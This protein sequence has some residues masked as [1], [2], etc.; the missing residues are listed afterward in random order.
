MQKKVTSSLLIIILFFLIFNSTYEFANSLKVTTPNNISVPNMDSNC[1]YTKNQMINYFNNQGINVVD[2]VQYSEDKKCSGKVVGSNLIPGSELTDLDK[3]FIISNISLY[4]LYFSYPIFSTISMLILIVLLIIN[5]GN[6]VVFL[7]FS[8]CVILNF[9][10]F[11]ITSYR[12][13]TDKSRIVQFQEFDFENHK[14]FSNPNYHL[15]EFLK[16]ND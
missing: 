10:S 1:Y 15:K 9:N 16:E 14:L 6:K 5:K 4:N 7:L 12:H 3:V 11:L 13:N 8:L 2:I